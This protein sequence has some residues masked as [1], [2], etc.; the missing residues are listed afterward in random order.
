M[1][2]RALAC[3]ALTATLSPLATAQ[4]AV[5]FRDAN[6]AAV[7]PVHNDV[8]AA[9]T[10]LCA[11]P[12]A[13][14]AQSGYYS[15]LPVGTQLLRAVRN[16]DLVQLVFDATLLQPTAGR[17]REDAIEQID[18]TALSTPGVR[19]VG[20]RIRLADGSEVSLAQ[21]LGE[22]APQA[23]ATAPPQPPTF[24]VQPFGTLAGK[25]IAVSPG[26]GY[27]WHSSLGWTTQRGDIDGLIEDIHTA[28]IANRYLI[29]LLE[30]MGAEVVFTREHGEVP[31]RHLD[32]ADDREPR[33]VLGGPQHQ[34]GTGVARNLD[35]RRRARR[36]HAHSEPEG[37]RD[38]DQVFELH[39]SSPPSAM[40]SRTTSAACSGSTSVNSTARSASIATGPYSQAPRQPEGTIA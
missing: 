10:H 30:N 26:H 6:P 38:T 25:R 17:S 16:G 14:E 32:R 15:N 34:I 2:S 24:A 39:E 13:A 36:V 4:V 28:Q 20:I 11:G 37:L 9:I 12:S 19:H 8:T 7:L 5:F 27:Y 33:G 31:L 18:K 22:L 29:P 1:L 21:A 40:N 3:L 23:V 35:P